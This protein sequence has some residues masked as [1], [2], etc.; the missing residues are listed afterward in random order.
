MKTGVPNYLKEYFFAE[1]YPENVEKAFLLHGSLYCTC[2][3]EHFCV[4][5]ERYESALPLI[6][7]M[8]QAKCKQCGKVILVFDESQNGYNAIVE[9]A[10]GYHYR[11]EYS[12][13]YKS[14]CRKCG[15]DSYKLEIKILNTGKKDLYMGSG[16]IINESNWD[17]AFEWVSINLECSSC[18][19][20]S[21]KYFEYET[22]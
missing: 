7:V 11:K 22:M 4:I 20:K 14:P 18:G 6:P 5:R 15:A 13:V 21:K 2:G 1:K 16:D 10:E 17:N 19:R 3:G 9:A 12:V 8:L